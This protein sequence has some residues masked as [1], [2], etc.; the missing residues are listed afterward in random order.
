LHRL[1]RAAHADRTQRQRG[2]GRLDPW[3]DPSGAV[4]RRPA[5]HG[6]RRKPAVHRGV[7]VAVSGP[8]SQDREQ[9]EL[10]A[11]LALDL[12][13][14]VEAP[15]IARAAVSELSR[16][17]RLAASLV[18]TLVLLVSEIVSNAVLHSSGPP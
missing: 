5:D 14:S 11:P 10:S 8:T 2:R 16:E 13:R 18:Q 6:R 17:L 4:A 12:Q 7:S 15:G 1:L 9:T 3:P